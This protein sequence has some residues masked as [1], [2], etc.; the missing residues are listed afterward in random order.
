MNASEKVAYLKGLMNGLEI[1]ANTKEG[2][3]FAAIIDALD[4]MAMSITDVEESYDELQE[5]VDAID[6]DLGE[7]EK[8]FYEDD[9]DCDC[10][11][12]DEEYMVECPRCGDEIY[13]DE[14]ML[15]EG[16]INCPNCGEHLEFDLDEME[17]DDCSCDGGHCKCDCED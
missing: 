14:E 10:G 9:C 11:C 16:E 7:L 17:D 4:E 12:E 8:D 3:L 1:D 13:L 15:D 2:K 6:E 5:V